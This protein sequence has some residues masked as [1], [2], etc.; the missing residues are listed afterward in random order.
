[1]SLKANFLSY[2]WSSKCSHV[3]PSEMPGLLVWG[4]ALPTQ[5][6]TSDGSF[7]DP[8]PVSLGYHHEGLH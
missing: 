4:T 6:G 3:M 7:T 5:S 8:D 1:M 2:M